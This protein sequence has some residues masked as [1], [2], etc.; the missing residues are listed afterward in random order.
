MGLSMERDLMIYILHTSKDL[1]RIRETNVLDI[2]PNI[3]LVSNEIPEILPDWW[4][5]RSRSHY[6]Y[7]DNLNPNGV[8]GCFDSHVRLFKKI[9]ELDEKG[10][11]IILE[12]DAVLSENFTEIVGKLVQEDMFREDYIYLGGTFWNPLFRVNGYVA[13]VVGV[14]TTCGIMYRNKKA[15]RSL[16]NYLMEINLT[17]DPID[18]QINHYSGENKFTFICNPQI[19]FQDK[20]FK[21]LIYKND[22]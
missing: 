9:L 22:K 21:S 12:S 4:L 14:N 2:I 8:F 3:E 7:K 11:Y 18:V 13:K 19:V 20:N 6:I 16:V 17:Q 15:I 1:Y 5:S 10:P